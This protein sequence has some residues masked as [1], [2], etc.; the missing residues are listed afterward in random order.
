MTEAFISQKAQN[1]CMTAE[2]DVASVLS[3]LD[4]RGNYAVVGANAVAVHVPGWYEFKLP[5][6][7][8]G[9]STASQVKTITI[10]LSLDSEIAIA[11]AVRK[12]VIYDGS[13]Y[14]IAVAKPEHLM[15]MYLAQ[16]DAL[17][18]RD[19]TRL[20]RHFRQDEDFE[21]VRNLLKGHPNYYNMY[22]FGLHALFELTR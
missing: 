13:T 5:F 3:Y 22:N 6:E 8:T 4:G 10:P 15:A 11:E 17:G 12:P 2:T 19:T 18:K 9:D 21:E 16:G 20:F 1:A 7:I 14:E